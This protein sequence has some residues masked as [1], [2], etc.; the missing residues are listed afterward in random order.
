MSPAVI[1]TAYLYYPFCT[2]GPNLCLWNAVFGVECLG[3]GMTRA[4]CYLV[5]GYFWEAIQFNILAIPM[6][7][8]LVLTSIRGTL[9]LW[10]IHIMGR[11]L[12]ARYLGR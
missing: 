5:R 2:E 12:I 6:L 10:S 11:R 1:L 4:V 7:F 9:Q 8:L 3:C